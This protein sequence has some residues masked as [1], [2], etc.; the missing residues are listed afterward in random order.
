MLN[1]EKVLADED[2]VDEIFRI[3]GKIE[4]DHWENL[5]YAIEK[6]ISS[7]FERRNCK[8]ERDTQD[9]HRVG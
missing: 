1:T 3:Y 9:A 4:S 2:I 6:G 8:D 7:V 5:R